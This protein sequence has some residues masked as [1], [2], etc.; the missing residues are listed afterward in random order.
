MSQAHTLTPLLL[1]ALILPHAALA[2]AH[3]DGPRTTDHPLTDL[4]GLHALPSPG[5]PGDPIHVI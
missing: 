2:S 3:A 5:R 1:G 4:T